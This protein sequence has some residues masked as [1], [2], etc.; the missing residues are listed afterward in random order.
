MSSDAK[1]ES[2]FF[3]VFYYQKYNWR[4]SSSSLL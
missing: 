1:L 2:N 3:I 4:S